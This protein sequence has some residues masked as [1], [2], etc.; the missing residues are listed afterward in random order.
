MSMPAG[1]DKPVPRLVVP[2]A[3]HAGNSRDTP[4]PDL[5]WVSQVIERTVVAALQVNRAFLK[6]VGAA[7]HRLATRRGR[8]NPRQR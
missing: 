5:R 4:A 7:A 3:P 8:V 1:D 6:E 2:P